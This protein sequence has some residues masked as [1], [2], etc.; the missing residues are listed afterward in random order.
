MKHCDF[1]IV[2]AGCLVTGLWYSAEHQGPSGGYRYAR[3]Y[4]TVSRLSAK[5]KS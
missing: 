4:L 3:Y 1:I 5:V 2:G